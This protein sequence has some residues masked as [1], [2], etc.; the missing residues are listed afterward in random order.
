[1]PPSKRVWSGLDSPEH[2][3][4]AGLSKPSVRPR[5]GCSSCTEGAVAA[6][7]SWGLHPAFT[8]GPQGH[9]LSA[10]MSLPGWEPKAGDLRDPP[11]DQW[12]SGAGS[13]SKSQEN[14]FL[15]RARGPGPQPLL[16]LL[17]WRKTAAQLYWLIILQPY[18]WGLPPGVCCFSR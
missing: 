17:F 16:P 8:M 5:R 18:P 10:Q 2:V 3:P 9:G 13:S 15:R 14:S 7:G 1:M 11:E 6:G 12:A 4:P